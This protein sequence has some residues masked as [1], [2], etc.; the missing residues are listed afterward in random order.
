GHIR[1][2]DLESLQAVG[3]QTGAPFEV[4]EHH[5]GWLVLDATD[6]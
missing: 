1:T 4:F 5:G 6:A 3:R 2:F